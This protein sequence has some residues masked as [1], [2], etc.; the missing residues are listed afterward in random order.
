MDDREANQREMFDEITALMGGVAK[1]FDLSESDA[2]AAIEAG[3]IEMKFDSD[4]NG[5]RF[6]LASYEGKI[7]RLY[8]GAIKSE[9]TKGH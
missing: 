1:A 2:I 6:V 7:A 9:D 4:S 8:A 5:N 3:S